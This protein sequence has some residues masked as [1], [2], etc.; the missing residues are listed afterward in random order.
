MTLSTRGQMWCQMKGTM[1]LGQPEPP[2]FSARVRRALRA[3]GAAVFIASVT[4]VLSGVGYVKLVF[5]WHPIPSTAIGCSLH[6]KF[7]SFN[8]MRMKSENVGLAT[9]CL[10]AVVQGREATVRDQRRI[11]AIRAWFDSRTDLWI[12]NI[13]TTAPDPGPPFIV[14]R[15]CEAERDHHV[16][17]NEDWIGYSPSKSHQRPICRGEWRELAAIIGGVEPNR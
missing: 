12:E 9:D 8:G 6:K 10:K 17:V 11:T 15:A 1:F 3:T 2:P 7:H 5:G 13:L 14:L 4:V 16:Y